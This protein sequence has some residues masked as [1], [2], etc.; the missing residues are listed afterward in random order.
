VTTQGERGRPG[1]R[2]PHGDH[3]QAGARGERGDP[4]PRPVMSRRATL[5]VVMFVFLVG[6]LLGW[7]SETNSDNIQEIQDRTSNEV[8]CPLYEVFLDSVENAP[9]QAADND[10][11]G[12]T[13]EAEQEQYDHAVK[14][15][16]DGYRT[17]D[18]NP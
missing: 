4:A 2:G 17:L 16:Q 18:C 14:V 5:A 1:E 10:R 9:P 3:G 11:D 6:L 12:K 13:T 8:L 7:R 15:I